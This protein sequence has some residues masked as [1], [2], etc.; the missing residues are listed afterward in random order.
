MSNTLGQ[1]KC[2]NKIKKES[3][4][5]SLNTS[6]LHNRQMSDKPNIPNAKTK[7]QGLIDDYKLLRE[8]IFLTPTCDEEEK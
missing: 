8:I 6:I 4:I 1:C 2:L 3:L 7:Y 5:R